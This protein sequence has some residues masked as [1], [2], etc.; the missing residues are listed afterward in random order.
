MSFAPNS[1][2]PSG[3]GPSEPLP[4]VPIAKNPSLTAAG[5]GGSA[6]EPS[7][8]PV[9]AALDGPAEGAATTAPSAGAKPTPDSGLGRLYGLWGSVLFFVLMAVFLNGALS[10]QPEEPPPD[11]LGLVS[12]GV[13]VAMAFVA[14]ALVRH[15]FRAPWFFWSTAV[16]C[17][18]CLT[19]NYLGLLL[20]LIGLTYLLRFRRE[21]FSGN[22]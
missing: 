11:W 18:C 10:L 6:S 7:P 5:A 14:F 2:P 16:I 19:T 22:R 15:R 1:F 4:A 17:A 3:S 12:V 9:P 13:L 20:G 21:F 8:G